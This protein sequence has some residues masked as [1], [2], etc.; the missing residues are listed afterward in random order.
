[1]VYD[2]TIHADRITNHTV[3]LTL[4][5]ML[6]IAVVFGFGLGKIPLCTCTG[7]GERDMCNMKW[8]K[9]NITNNK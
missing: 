6:K 1:M 3:A 8:D 4:I 7:R 9:K 5:P 2:A